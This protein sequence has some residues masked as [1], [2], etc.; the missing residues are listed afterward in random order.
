[1]V[2]ILGHTKIANR[3][4]STLIDTIH[5][6]A[7]VVQPA[8]MFYPVNTIQLVEKKSPT[9]KKRRNTTMHQIS[10]WKKSRFKIWRSRWN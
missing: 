9:S 7:P 6:V 3:K 1:M 8:V 10:H 4:K 5:V 2:A